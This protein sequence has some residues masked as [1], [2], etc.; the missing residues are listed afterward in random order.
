MVADRQGFHLN[1][2]RCDEERLVDMEP[3]LLELVMGSLRV[4]PEVLSPSEKCGWGSAW[5]FS[6]PAQCRVYSNS[7]LVARFRESLWDV[8]SHV[9]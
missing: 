3:D 5:V 6:L 8:L 1:S 2:I 9:V 7:S 4:R